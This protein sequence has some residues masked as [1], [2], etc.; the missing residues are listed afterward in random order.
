MKNIRT[1]P[2]TAPKEVNGACLT[3]SLLISLDFSC[4]LVLKGFA[5]SLIC[6]VFSFLFSNNC[7]YS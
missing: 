7:V 5:Y 1:I 4:S 3:N 6:I 2:V